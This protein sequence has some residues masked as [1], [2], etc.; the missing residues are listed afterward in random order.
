MK[1][2]WI[3]LALTALLLCNLSGCKEAPVEVPQEDCGGTGYGVS[4]KS[5][6]TVQDLYFLRPGVNRSVVA[7]NLGSSLANALEES[8]TDTYRLTDGE[9]LVLTYNVND[10]ISGAVWTDTAGKKQDF[11]QY[12]NDIGII[13]NYKPDHE[14]TEKEPEKEPETPD[15]TP[16]PESKPDETPA[17]E[18][19]N[20][21]FSSKRYTYL[22][23]DQILKK[24]VERETV[25]SALGKPNSFSSI[26][27]AKDSYLIDV[28]N[29][30]DGSTL[31][32]DYGY[33]RKTLRA[34]QKAEGSTVKDY[35]GTWGQEE[36]PKG[37]IRFTRNQSVF[38]TL[39]KNAKPSEI[40]RRF[41]EPDWLEGSA[42]H[43]RD[44]YMLLGGE[45]YY[46]DFG[47]NHTGLTAVVLQ[48]ANGKVVNYTLK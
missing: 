12:L 23:A 1:K 9:T 15:E 3:A 42:D 13:S 2:R 19:D 38:N 37:Y 40:Y 44:A 11:F 20:N 16:A 24:G 30:E 4:Q 31:Y 14:E 10:K 22:M 47:P 25:V 43:Y 7:E 18:T 34:V 29:M 46:L 5:V 6:L 48:K 17:P 36:K 28:Y 32:L 39:K 41:G 21:Y 8:A 35:I 33:N 45:V 26:T 27:F